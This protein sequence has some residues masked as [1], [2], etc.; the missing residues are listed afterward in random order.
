MRAILKDVKGFVKDEVTLFC[1]APGGEIGS[2][3]WNIKAGEKLSND[4]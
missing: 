1:V 4:C 2:S 3:R